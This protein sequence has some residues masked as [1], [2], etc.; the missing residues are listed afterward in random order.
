M[1]CY[2]LLTL[3]NKPTETVDERRK[4]TQ[5]HCIKKVETLVVKTQP[6]DPLH[7]RPP[8]IFSV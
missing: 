3:K 4:L 1:V 7:K 2:L 8:S 5:N 6:I